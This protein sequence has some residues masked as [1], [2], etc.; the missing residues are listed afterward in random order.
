M[1]NKL[2]AN[3]YYDMVIRDWPDSKVAEMAK[4]TMNENLAG[5]KIKK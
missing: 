5:E 4:K 3:L 1:G 2:S